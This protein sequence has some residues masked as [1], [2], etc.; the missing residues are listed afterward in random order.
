M[1]HPALAS[2]GSFCWNLSCPAYAQIGH[3]NLRRFGKTRRGVQRYQCRLCQH[4]FTATKGTLFY[5][6]R[7]PQE[8]ILECLALLA[9]RTSLAALHRVKGI[10]EETVMAWLK[11]AA[12]HV[13][14][15]ETLLF[16]HYRLSRAQMDALWSYV[17]HKGEKGGAPRSPSVAPSGAG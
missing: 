10:K 7:R 2:P 3:G 12:A 4:T 13:E 9:E 1:T 17:G 5:G 6:C 11:K 14:T 8:Q 16:A 15:L